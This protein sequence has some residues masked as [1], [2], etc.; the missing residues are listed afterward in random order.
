M[1]KTERLQ[2]FIDWWSI[3]I[4]GDE[5]SEAQSFLNKLVQAFGHA[6]LLEVGKPET[7]VRRKRN[8]KNSVSF[9]DYV[10]FDTVLIE[11]KKRGENLAKH[12]D[13]LEEYWKGL[14]IKPRY[15]ILCDF[16]EIWIYDFPVQ[17]YEPVDRIQIENLIDR[18]DALEFMVAGS[19]LKPVFQ[20][21]LV[22]VTKDAAFSL[23]KVFQS[24]KREV[25]E[26][27][28]QRY[29]LQCMLA[30]FAEDIGLLPNKIFT[31]IIEECI[32]KGDN[33]YDLITLLFFFMN[34]E[35][36]AKSGRFAGV[37]YFN[38][39]IFNEI[40]PVL[41][42]PI[43]LQDLHEAAKQN[44]SKIKPAIFGTI[45]E[46]SLTN[47]ER[48][49]LGAHFTNEQDIKL[50]IDPVIVRP[51]DDRIEQATTLA[52][53]QAL[54]NELCDYIV[55]DPACGS[56]NFLYIAYIEIKKL[57]RRLLDKSI[58]LGAPL[59][60][61]YVKVQQFYGYDI[62]PFAVELAK[63]TLMI[64]KKIAV[65]A[66]GSD[67]NPLPLDNMDAN[68]HHD[69]AL[70]AE[71]VEFDACIGN[72]PYQ[73]GAD[74]STQFG[75]E[76][77]NDLRNKYPEVGGRADY[78]VYWFRK[79]HQL[80]R[81]GTRAGLVGTNTI[82]QNVSREAGLDY[83][84]ANEGHIYD[85]VSSMPWSGSAVVHVSIACWSKG[86]A[87]I[88][89]ALLRFY[90]GI[91]KSDEQ[92]RI[93]WRVE[94]RPEINSALSDNVDL[95]GAQVLSINTNPQKVFQGQT[96]GYTSFFTLDQDDVSQMIIKDKR[97]RDII[98]GFLSGND[99]VSRN[100]GKPRR[101]IIDFEQR[102]IFDAKSYRL[103]FQR[104][105]R[106]V[107]P[108]LQAKANRE[109]EEN[110]AALEKNPQ[111]RTK[112]GY[113]NSLRTWWQH[114]RSRPELNT[115]IAHMKRCIVT[116]RHSKR[117]IF[118]F[119]STKIKIGDSMK[120]YAF[121]DDYT[122]GII[123]SNSHWQWVEGRGSTIKEDARN[124]TTT[125]YDAFPFPQQPSNEQIKAVADAARTLH[126]FRRERMS[127]SDTLTLRIL[128]RSLE[129]PGK[130]LCVICTQPW[131]KR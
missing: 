117:P 34:Y 47:T 111:S 43:Q 131:I 48:H 88:T 30:L 95:S 6:G 78:C 21:N 18:V 14:E 87:P 112:S 129:Q 89:P 84:V 86:K 54:H 75:L 29:I 94:Q 101:F 50:I 22:E 90:D 103:A 109:I 38:G 99:L 60:E 12:Y 69:D 52:D 116:S 85:A 106:S 98:F 61:K 42:S 107:L 91:D 115:A 45:F 122:F 128:Y 56:G 114:F 102:D 125:T 9:A 49:Q 74:I 67:E 113:Q 26:K 20:N 46:D 81:E 123:Q 124:T 10:M 57:E 16:D 2:S 66:I 63:V 55:L 70:F 120:L 100:G 33:T 7:R 119:V 51:W 127:K 39:G 8:G 15:A 37:D 28:A 17:F 118:D 36:G 126:E 31:R 11:M 62:E 4:T 53:V 108:D 3:N 59:P 23:S 93:I 97:S 27:I 25:G 77:A 65:D 83:I 24:L 76:Y 58:E 82:T 64:A 110:E 105:E 32:E 72:P 80:M 96:P 40:H 19:N 13:Q 79:A 92:D 121:D 41:L 1:S 71:W 104:I 68:I 130:T 35:G 73:S 44:W 5:K